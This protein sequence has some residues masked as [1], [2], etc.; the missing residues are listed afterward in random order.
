M[1]A[2]KI[3]KH[4]INKI[5]RDLDIP[6]NYEREYGLILQKEEIE[7]IEIEHDIYGRLQKLVPVAA[8]AWSKMKGHAEKEGVI[9][10][11][12][13]AY[14]SVDK[15]KEIIQKKLEFGQTIYD[16]LRV[17]AAPGYSEH[18]T[19]RALDLTSE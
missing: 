14:R 11:V 19:G 3:Y 8:N 7:L 6:E 9:L 4:K 10:N 2:M 12:V 1:E 13:S 17:C 15:Q 18:H 16:V 5:L